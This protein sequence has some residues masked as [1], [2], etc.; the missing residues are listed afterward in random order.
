[1]TIN[2]EITPSTGENV[3]DSSFRSLESK[4]VRGTYFVTI[5]YGLALVLRLVSSIVLSRLFAPELFG[6]LAL[7]TTIVSG[8]YLFSH[9]GLQDSIIQDPRGDN[10]TFLNTAWTVQVIR[11]MGLFLVTI[12]LAWPVARFYHDSRLLWVLPAL[13]LGNAIA[14]LTSSSLLTLARHMG[15]GKLSAL[16]LLQQFVQF[17]VTL[18]WALF[19]P[20]LMALVAGRLISE[21]VR[22]ILSYFMMPELRPRFTWDRESLRALVKFGRWILVGTAL[23]FLA[24]QSDRL[25]LAKLI[26]FQL[27]GVYGIAFQISDV[28]RQIILQFCG[29]VGFPFIARFSDRPRREYQDILLKYRMPVLAAGGLMLILVICTGDLFVTHVYD[30]RYHNAAWMIGILTVGLWHTLLYST[31]NP[32]ILS[33]QKAHYNALGYFV[34]CISLYLALPI[35]FHLL[36]MTGAVLAVAVADLPMYF[37]ALYSAHREG[38]RLFAQD[39]WLTLAFIIALVAAVAIRSSLGFGS[40]FSGIRW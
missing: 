5:S 22:T 34:Y 14:G 11:G 36:G 26:S 37:V 18:I 8:M 32:A 28:P 12:P 15:V 9:I 10:P 33:L 16:E 4:A 19:Q 17:A 35:G 6:V 39:A 7:V 21:L 23:T 31:T 38:I 1:M 40:P 13:G 30:H 3:E 25:I 24:S 27:L 20:S 29:R 2:A